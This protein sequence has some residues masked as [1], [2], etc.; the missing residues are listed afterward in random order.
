MQRRLTRS[1]W[2]RTHL[3]SCSFACSWKSLCN[4]ETKA[5]S[6]ELSSCSG[7]ISC[8]YCIWMYMNCHYQRGEETCRKIQERGCSVK[9]CKT[10]LNELKL[11]LSF[12]SNLI[13]TLWKSQKKQSIAIR[14]S[15]RFTWISLRVT[16]H[17]SPSLSSPSFQAWPFPCW[18]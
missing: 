12:N 18:I 9:L 5:F 4:T 7:R 14:A 1:S 10:G 11:E 3:Q 16:L 15:H 17:H 8:T 13:L 2:K 6:P